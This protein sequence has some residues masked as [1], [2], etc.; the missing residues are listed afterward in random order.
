MLNDPLF[1]N[2][3]KVRQSSF[4]KKK[5]KMVE[6]EGEVRATCYVGVSC[7]NRYSFSRS[8]SARLVVVPVATRRATL[9]HQ[10]FFNHGVAWITRPTCSVRS[11]AIYKSTRYVVGTASGDEV[12]WGRA[13]AR[14]PSNHFY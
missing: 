1:Y 12:E 7:N 10:F 3:K 8:H 11:R 4:S 9:L 2:K 14:F 5:K 6:E 13:S